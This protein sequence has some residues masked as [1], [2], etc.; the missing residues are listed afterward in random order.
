MSISDTSKVCPESDNKKIKRDIY[1][2]LKG[3]GV[4][5]KG[6]LPQELVGTTYARYTS[7]SFQWKL[8]SI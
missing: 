3:V 1:I 7:G 2:E 8:Q 4:P 6:N 5:G